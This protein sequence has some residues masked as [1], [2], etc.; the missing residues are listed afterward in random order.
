MKKFTYIIFLTIFII[1]IPISYFISI[2][3]LVSLKYETE[4]GECISNV[5]GIDLCLQYDIF[6]GLTYFFA[7]LL[8]LFVIFPK[9]IIKK[10]K[11][12]KLIDLNCSF[13]ELKFTFEKGLTV[14]DHK[15][16]IRYLGL[17]KIKEWKSKFGYIFNIYSN[18]HF[19]DNEPHF[20]FDNKEKSVSCKMSF[21]GNIFESNEKNEIDRK[22]LKELKYFLSMERTQETIISKWNN[23]NPKLK[24]KRK[25]AGNRVGG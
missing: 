10:E 16:G 1:G 12:I 15:D 7:L 25:T 22:V 5:S 19:I 8:L 20:H 18:D 4:I 23:K 24:Y 21:D 17:E 9:K 13:D 14:E 6:I 11:T 2:N 3:T